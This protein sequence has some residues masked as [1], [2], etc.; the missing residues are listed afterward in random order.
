MVETMVR[1]MAGLREVNGPLTR[2]QALQRLGLAGAAVPLAATILAACGEQE[3]PPA[4]AASTPAAP[5]TSESVEG[6]TRL[7]LPAVA[8]PVGGRE[9]QLV[10]VE[11]ETL[12]V[13]ALIDDGVAYTFWTFNGTVPGPMI[14]VRQGDTVELTLKNNPNNKTPHNID[15]H[16]VTGPGGG[17]KYTVV[18]PGGSATIRFKALNPG[19]YVYHCAV[20]PIPMHVSSGMYGLIVVEP[21]GGLPPVDR[22]FYVMQGDFYLSGQRGQPGRHGFSL[23]KCLAEQPDY[24]VFNGSV[25][26]LAG[27]RALQAKVGERVRIFFGN[28][29][30]NLTSSFHVIGE[31][32]DRVALEAGSVWAENVQTTS[33]PPGGATIVEFTLEVPGDYVMVDHALGRLMKGA[34][35]VIHVE[36]PENPEVFEVV[37]PGVE[38]HAGH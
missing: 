7:P 26:A 14:R 34:S 27:E 17:A 22:E 20:P 32:F 28:G 37:V 2:R 21:P 19:V 35:G 8:P 36:G 23:E 10:K 11:L 33:V 38:L 1:T 18:N 6:L 16:A 3:A 4:S 30:V 15:L 24:V 12:E 31:I 29:G 13:E 5:A 9:P 25:G